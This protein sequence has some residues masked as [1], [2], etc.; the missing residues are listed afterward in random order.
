MQTSHLGPGSSN[1]QQNRSELWNSLAS[2]PDLCNKLSE[3]VIVSNTVSMQVPGSVEE[4]RLFSK[5][6]FINPE[7]VVQ[8]LRR[9]TSMH[10]LP[11]PPNKC[12][13]LSSSPF[14]GQWPSGQQ[15]R[16]GVQR[17][18]ASNSSSNSLPQSLIA[19]T[20]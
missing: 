12:G 8:P 17:Q 6:A 11:L 1:N 9:S 7:Q 14:R 15:Q 19:M 16:S 2:N 5:L 3:F 20:S 4:E 10:A 18:W 13:A